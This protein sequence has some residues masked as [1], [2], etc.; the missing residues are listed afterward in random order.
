MKWV[1][2]D[3]YQEQEMEGEVEHPRDREEGVVL[4]APPYLWY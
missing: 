1:A 4:V 2:E 3:C